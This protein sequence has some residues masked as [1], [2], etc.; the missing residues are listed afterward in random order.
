MTGAPAL[1]AQVASAQ[2]TGVVRDQDGAV[3]PGATVITSNPATAQS[4]AVATNSF[5]LYNVSGLSPGEYEVRVE[6]AGFRPLI[7]KGIRLETGET[8]RLDLE[9][10]VGSVT[11]TVTVT[12]DAPILQSE[13]AT[14]GQIVDHEQIDR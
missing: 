2:L 9:L 14:L 13:R 1:Q 7:R 5:G 11:E 12:G 3:L 10:F 8:A 4:R 6:L